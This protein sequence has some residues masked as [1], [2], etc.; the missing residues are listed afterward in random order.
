MGMIAVVVVAAEIG[1]I[2]EVISQDNTQSPFLFKAMQIMSR[3]K[4]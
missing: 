2:K 4:L 1:K 3:R